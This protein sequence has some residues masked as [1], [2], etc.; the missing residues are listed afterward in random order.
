MITD[1]EAEKAASEIYNWL[2]H[3]KYGFEDA[4]RILRKLATYLKEAYK[5]IKEKRDKEW[6]NKQL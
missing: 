1:K 4:A 5:Q 3:E 6:E 2:R